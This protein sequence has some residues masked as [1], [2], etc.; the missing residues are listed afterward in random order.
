MSGW[1]LDLG[2]VTQLG[3]DGTQ[4]EWL[5]SLAIPQYF[6]PFKKI[7]LFLKILLQLIYHVF[8][9]AM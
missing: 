7:H 5:Y 1:G 3:R 6:T 2:Q 4:L 9:S 8:I